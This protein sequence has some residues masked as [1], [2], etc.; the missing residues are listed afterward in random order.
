MVELV[1]VSSRRGPYGLEWSGQDKEQQIVGAALCG[2]IDSWHLRA[3]SPPDEPLPPWATAQSND[4]N[5]KTIHR[6]PC[7]LVLITTPIDLARVVK[8]DKPNLRVTHD[9]EELTKPR[10]AELLVSFRTS[11]SQ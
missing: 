10:L 2:G 7:D 8:I 3:L 5:S 11:T 4:T 1:R 6:T 9:V